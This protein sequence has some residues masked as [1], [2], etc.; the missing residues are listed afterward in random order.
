LSSEEETEEECVAESVGSLDIHKVKSSS[1]S[2]LEGQKHDDDHRFAQT[3]NSPNPPPADP[4]KPPPETE[5]PNAGTASTATAPEGT[6]MNW[7]PEFLECARIGLHKL[8]TQRSL[9]EQSHPEALPL[10]DITVTEQILQPWLGRE[11][12]FLDWLAY[13]MERRLGEKRK[14]FGY[15]LF[16]KD[17]IACAN[18][19]APDRL[20]SEEFKFKVREASWQKRQTKE[21]ESA[22][23]RCK[24]SGRV[25]S[26]FCACE[27][28][29]EEARRMQ[30]AQKETER[31][32][33]IIE[34]TLNRPHLVSEHQDLI[35]RYLSPAHQIPD[36]GESC[37]NCSDGKARPSP[38]ARASAAVSER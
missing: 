19:W 18:Q 3:A 25:G 6:K 22:C 21:R 9:F 8:A 33:R 2:T 37:A 11:I 12:G 38:A 5:A 24:D 4:K 14:G 16:K 15:G 36:W 26:E 34:A 30:E 17:S 10:P 29:R 27:R 35:L 7:A 20:L 31:K 1:S 32:S 28:G 13:A 23:E